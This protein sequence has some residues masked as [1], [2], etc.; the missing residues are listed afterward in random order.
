MPLCASES[1]RRSSTR[2]LAKLNI[3]DNRLCAPGTKTL[4]EALQGN[5]IMTELNISGNGMGWDDWY[6]EGSD[7]SG[8]EALASAIP[9]MGALATI[10]FGT[11]QAVTMTATMTEAN[12]SGKLNGYEAHVVAAFLPKCR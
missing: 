1:L 5:Q 2:A 9:T 11:K 6:D 7:M 10:T 3:R 4:A 12:F 8:V